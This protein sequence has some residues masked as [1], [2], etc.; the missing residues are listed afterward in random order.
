MS[1]SRSSSGTT[2]RSRLDGAGLRGATGR[3]RPRRPRGR[4]ARSWSPSSPRST[5]PA[6][7]F[8]PTLSCAG[9]TRRSVEPTPISPLLAEAV[10]AALDALRRRP[11]AMSTRPS[12]PRWT[13]SAMTATLPGSSSTAPGD[14][15]SSHRPVP[16]WQ[17]S[18]LD[19]ARTD[20]ARAARAAARPRC[21][22]QGACRRSSRRRG[23]TRPST[24]AAHSSRL[25]ATS[26]SAA[27]HRPA[28]GAFGFRTSPARSD[29]P[30]SVRPSWSGSRSGGLATSSTAARRWVRGGR[31][32]HH[33][34]D[35]RSGV[36][37]V[38]PWRTVTVAAPTCLEAN[39]ASTAAI[40]RG[41]SAV[42]WLTRPWTR[43]AIRRCRRRRHGDAGLAVAQAG[44]A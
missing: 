17:R 33:I 42:E 20:V 10:A 5:L 9:S 41:V 15:A 26:R 39:V 29:R 16:G 13:Q 37:V 11:M 4:A 14:A 28:A 23:S 1:T 7:G 27:S 21:D 30:P 24:A 31:V 8:A 38:S 43:G 18:S 36:P 32:M 19:R 34:L 2:G 25:A 6:A 3:A 22:R 35:P 44:V 12:A 40:V